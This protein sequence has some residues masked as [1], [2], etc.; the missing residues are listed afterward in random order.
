MGWSPFIEGL[1]I[2]RMQADYAWCT[3]LG[4]DEMKWKKLNLSSKEWMFKKHKEYWKTIEGQRHSKLKIN[5]N[6]SRKLLM[7]DKVKLSWTVGLITGHCWMKGHLYKIGTL[8]DPT[9]ARCKKSDETAYHMLCDCESLAA[10]RVKYFNQWFLQKHELK[11]ISVKKLA[12]FIMDAGI[13]ISLSKFNLPRWRKRQG[14]SLRA[15]RPGFD[16]GCRRGGDFSSLLRVQTGPGVHST[17]YK[18]STG[19]FLR[20]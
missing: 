17:S 10:L 18:M 4:V 11:E 2:A 6:R 7:I 12:S 15:G 20:E 9:C 14:A 5:K 16:P 19:E 3:I 8:V 1:W 13:L